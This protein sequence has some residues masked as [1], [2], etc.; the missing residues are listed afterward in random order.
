MKLSIKPTNVQDEQ[1]YIFIQY[2][3]IGRPT[4]RARTAR[5]DVDPYTEEIDVPFCKA[6]TDNVDGLVTSTQFIWAIEERITKMIS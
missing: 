5:T 4:R 6:L 1:K 2:I 3:Y